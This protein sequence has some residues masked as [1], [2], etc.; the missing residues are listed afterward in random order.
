M[1][2]FHIW[3]YAKK[4]PSE[5]CCIRSRQIWVN[6][7]LLT[8]NARAAVVLCLLFDRDFL[9]LPDAIYTFSC[10]PHS[11]P[12]QNWEQS[13]CVFSRGTTRRLQKGR[14]LQLQSKKFCTDFSQRLFC[15]SPSVHTRK[16]KLTFLYRLSV[17]RRRLIEYIL[18]GIWTQ[19]DGIWEPVKLT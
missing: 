16:G 18:K 12:A 3:G 13:G 4:P 9:N 17:W 1:R 2:V 11:E 14:M 6:F 7:F 10:L 8:A 5:R 19:G 15:S